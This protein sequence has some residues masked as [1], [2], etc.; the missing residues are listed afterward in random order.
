MQK[1]GNMQYHKTE[2]CRMKILQKASDEHCWWDFLDYK[3]EKQHLSKHEERQISDFIENRKYISLCN[4]FQ[5]GFFPRTLPVKMT[6]NKMGTGKKRVV[7]T[8]PGDEGIFLKFIAFHLFDYDNQFSSN[9]YAFRRDFGVKEALRRLLKDRRADNSYCFKVDISNY[10]NSINEELLIEKLGFLRQQDELLYGM[11]VRLLR[12]KRVLERECVKEEMHGAMAGTPTAPFFANL[13]MTE[14][15]CFFEKEDVLYFR[16][17]DDILLFAESKELLETRKQQLYEKIARLDLAINPKKEVL[18]SPGEAIEFLGF[19]Y[20]DGEIDLSVSTIRKI[21]AKI[22]RKAE[23]LRRWQRKKGLPAE[24]A[25]IGFINA[26]NRQ[27]YGYDAAGEWEDEFC[28]S[29]WFFP[30]LTTDAGLREVDAY[31]QQYIRYVVTGR[32]Y[33]GNFRIRYETLKEWGYRSLVHEYY[34]ASRVSVK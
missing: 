34:K 22:R 17:S 25:A 24:K 23:A 20:K 27:F 7:Y 18:Y 19:S 33:K 16:Y 10:F 14:I 6:I 21:K 12:E 31:M 15:D 26:M 13:Y 5:K 30:N 28:W 2:P 4:D 11:F 1:A 3:I 29:R 32:H 8:F 9:C